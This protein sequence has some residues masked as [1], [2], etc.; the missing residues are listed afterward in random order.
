MVCNGVERN[1]AENDSYLVMDE[2]TTMPEISQ[3]LPETLKICSV[4]SSLIAKQ[5]SFICTEFPAE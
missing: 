3:I 4:I 1:R 5:L 2:E